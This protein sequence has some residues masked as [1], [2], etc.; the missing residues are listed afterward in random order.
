MTI[1]L[2]S[3]RVPPAV[4]ERYPFKALYYGL[5]ATVRYWPV[6]QFRC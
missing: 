1:S 4:R 6:G 5:E 3:T 2:L